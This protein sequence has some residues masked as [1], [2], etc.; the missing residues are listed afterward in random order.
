MAKKPLTAKEIDYR[1]K[2]SERLDFALKRLGV[3]PAHLKNLIG[4]SHGQVSNVMRGENELSAFLLYEL[5]RKF[6]SIDLNELVCGG[7]QYPQTETLQI[8][9]EPEESEVYVLKSKL[10]FLERENLDLYRQVSELRKRVDE[11]S[12]VIKKTKV[13]TVNSNAP[14]K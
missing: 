10:Q 3:I 11:L 9:A 1:K 2:F 5:K 13:A 8:A 4:M 7:K 6:P 14:V 12:L